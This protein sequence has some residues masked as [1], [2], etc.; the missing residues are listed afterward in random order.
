M[1]Q[2]VFEKL[3][4]FDGEITAV[5]LNP[6]FGDLMG[7]QEIVRQARGYERRA[8]LPA[9]DWNFSQAGSENFSEPLAEVLFGDGLSKRVMVEVSG[10]EPPASTLRIQTGQLADLCQ[11]A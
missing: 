9:F 11:L 7:A 2:A 1:N 10:L 6:P 4:V 3:Y 8:A 5:V